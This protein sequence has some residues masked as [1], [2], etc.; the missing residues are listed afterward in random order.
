MTAVMDRASTPVVRDRLY[1][2]GKWVASQ[3]GQSAHAMNPTT[4]QVI[5]VVVDGG[6]DDVRAAIQAARTAFDEGPWPRLT[7]RERAEVLRRMVEI[8][9]RRID[10]ITDLDVAEV[11]RARN[12]ARKRF[13][14]TPIDHFADLIDNVLPTFPFSEPVQ[15]MVSNLGIGQG[16]IKREPYGVASIITPYNAP[17]LLAVTKLGPAL[18]AGCTTILKPSPYTPLSA[19]IVAEIADEAGLPPGVLNVVTGSPAVSELLT[20]HRD[21]DL[22]SFTG[23][24]VVGRMIMAQASPTLKKVVLELGGKSANV[25]CEDADLSRVIPNVVANFT[26]NAGQGCSMLTRTLVHESI[27]DELVE[28]LLAAVNDIKVG[29]P[30]DPTVTMGPL[31]SAAQRDKVESLI[32]TGID[33]GARLAH[34]GGRPAG[35][36]TGYFVEPTVFVG[37]DNAMAIAQREFFGPVTVV[38]P[39]A[40]DDEAVRIANDSD[41]GLA[42]GVWSADVTRAYRI[43]DRIRAGMVTV[44]GGPPDASPNSPFGGYKQSGIGREWGRWGLDEYLQTKAMLWRAAAG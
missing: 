1:I 27:H 13:V 39:F 11:G 40:D 19:F 17:F 44:N 16:V 12:L 35:L 14:E 43:A 22:V 29:D 32:Q 3:S 18:A 25:I 6:V 34:G 42:G 10:E 23:S 28:R 30:N 24:D 8:M 38:I 4:E 20:T 36:P 2:G 26:I 9:R 7:P 41:Y 31:I 37:V 5:G 33:E 21:I 15:P